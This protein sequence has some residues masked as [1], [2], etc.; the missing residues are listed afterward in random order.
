MTRR[1]DRSPRPNRSSSKRVHIEGVDERTRH[2]PTK[3]NLPEMSG[4][5]LRNSVYTV[6]AL[7]RVILARKTRV[8]AAPT[9]T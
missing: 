4:L 2:G 8:R 1:S 3:K 5:R 9:S 6:K 7:S